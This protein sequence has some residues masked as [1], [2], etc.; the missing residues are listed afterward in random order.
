MMGIYQILNTINENKYIGQSKDVEKRWKSHLRDLRKKRHGNTHLSN[1]FKLYGEEFFEFSVLEE[2]EENRLD[3]REEFWINEFPKEKLY[4]ENFNITNLKGKNNPFYGKKHKKD[5]IQKMSNWGK[6]NYLGENNPNFGKR[7][8]FEN[9]IK[10]TLK[11]PQTKLSAE[12]VLK[13]KDLLLEG[14]LKDAEIGKMFDISRNVVTRIASGK[15]WSNITGGRVIDHERR[16]LRL[17]GTKR[18]NKS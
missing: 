16:G 11:H 17:K 6:E 8:S 12:S 1:A 9:R 4:N 2:C 13:I 3:E 7:W 10:N 15:R 14:K 18:K 5:S